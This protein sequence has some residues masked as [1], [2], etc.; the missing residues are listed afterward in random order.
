M[1]HWLADGWLAG[2]RRV[3]SP[4]QEQRPADAQVSLVVIHNISL[5]PDDF[6]GDW[7]ERFFANRLDPAAHPYFSTIIGLKVSSH[8]LI[9]RSGRVVQFVGCDQRAWHA[10]K[11]S[12]GGRDDCNDFS[13]GIELHGNDHLP[14]SKSQYQSLWRLLDALRSRY[15]IDAVAGHCHIAP[16]RKTD[17]G[18]GFDWAALRR[19]YPALGLPPEIL[20]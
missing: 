13:V 5:P 2:V 10:G 7:V 4:N 15:P 6:S 3:R 9:R 16:G 17:P 11:S 8:F 20:G 18:T 19:R 1:R 12:W 14:Y